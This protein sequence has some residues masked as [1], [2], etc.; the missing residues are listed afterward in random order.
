MVLAYLADAVVV[1]AHCFVLGED[2]PM[3]RCDQYPAVLVLEGVVEWAC[4]TD[5]I[6]GVEVAGQD[7]DV[8]GLVWHRPK[9]VVQVAHERMEH[10]V[11]ALGHPAR[12]LDL[13]VVVHEPAGH[14]LVELAALV[15]RCRHMAQAFLSSAV[16]LHE[17]VLALGSICWIDHMADAG[18][19]HSHERLAEQIVRLIQVE[20]WLLREN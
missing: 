6:A 7:L 19:S 11:A 18:H 10:A 16:V 15:L 17:E 2:L 14:T 9:T 20:A 4:H 5:Q 8:G 12:T 3:S 1:A 13:A